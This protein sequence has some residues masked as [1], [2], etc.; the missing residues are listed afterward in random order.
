MNKSEIENLLMSIPPFID[1][2]NRRDK[3]LWTILTDMNCIILSLVK[4]EVY[5]EDYIKQLVGDYMFYEMII[6]RSESPEDFL[7]ISIYLSGMVEVIVDFCI[8]NEVWEAMENI[9]KF[10]DLLN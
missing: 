6:N 2:K 5:S 3:E 10:N 4:Y 7:I 1:A 8:E 9:K